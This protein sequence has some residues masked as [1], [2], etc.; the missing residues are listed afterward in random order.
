MLLNT[1]Y[2]YIL[3]VTFMCQ[4]RNSNP[5]MQEPAQ[6]PD[7]RK[8]D[9]PP[10]VPHVAPD[11]ECVCA[12]CGVVLSDSYGSPEDLASIGSPATSIQGSK[13]GINLF[14]THKLGGKELDSLPGLS[15]AR[16]LEIASRDGTADTEGRKKRKAA[17]AYLSRFSNACSKLGLTHA[18]SEHAWRLFARVYG[19]LCDSD[20]R[21]INTS[22]IACY[23]IAA[24][25]TATS[26]RV[27][28][29]RTIARAV[30]FS[31]HSKSVRDMYCIRRIVE[32][33]SEAVTGITRPVLTASS[34]WIRGR[35]WQ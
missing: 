13:S 16:S 10:H 6:T 34:K 30:M 1:G 29:E 32:T 23:A 5:Y 4:T 19:E 26:R 7:L 12:K 31:F 35:Y 17:G 8:L 18:E 33:R 15:T 20:R 2:Y 14:I 11:G 3:L 28:G 9:C 24:G 27:L 22:E 21:A 25:T